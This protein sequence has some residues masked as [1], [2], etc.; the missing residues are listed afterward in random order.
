MP[1]IA[2]DDG[3]RDMRESRVDA[4]GRTGGGITPDHVTDPSTSLRM[5]RQ[6]RRDTAPELRLRRLLFARGLRY[7]V[8]APLPGMPRRR[9][10]VLFTRRRVAVFVDGCFW[11]S[12]PVHGTVP[13][14]NRDWWV[15]KLDKNM[16]RDRETDTHLSAIGWTVLR[17]W[18]HEDMEL[19][20]DIVEQFIRNRGS[21][22]GL[23]VEVDS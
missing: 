3:D 15:A 7:R 2:R 12:C 16:A 17:F 9:A 19:A 21:G 11:H 4:G 1:G 10:D 13:R 14:S 6:A 22:T 18:E 23:P 5:S 20:A 8:D